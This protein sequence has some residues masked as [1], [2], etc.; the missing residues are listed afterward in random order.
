MI[1]YGGF[2]VWKYI[3]LTNNLYKILGSTY[4]LYSKR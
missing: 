4:I 3:L 1:G 2:L